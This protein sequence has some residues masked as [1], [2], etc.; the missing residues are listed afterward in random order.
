MSARIRYEATKDS[1]VLESI[2]VFVSK[3]NGARYKVFIDLNNL[4]FRIRNE[5]TKTNTVMG[6]EHINNLNVLKRTVKK[7]LE[8]L[9]VDFSDEIRNRTFGR[10]DKGYTQKQH[11]NKL[12]P[13]NP[14]E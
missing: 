2:R 4:T 1:K 3:I 5:N 9:G 11:T 6:G 13:D 12:L 14:I 10:C 8:R 7:H